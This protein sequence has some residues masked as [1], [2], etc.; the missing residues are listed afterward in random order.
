MSQVLGSLAFPLAR[1]QAGKTDV[2]LFR[3]Q[4]M[5][6]LL[7]VKKEMPKCWDTQCHLISLELESLKSTLYHLKW[8]E[9][10]LPFSSLLCC[11]PPHAQCIFNFSLVYLEATESCAITQGDRRRTAKQNGCNA[12][13][14]CSTGSLFQQWNWLLIESTP[15]C[16]PA[17]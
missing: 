15:F 2:L 14:L 11:S 16:C 13:K 3:G 17:P 5:C 7:W 8:V 6:N 4:I 1:P 9:I 12:E 10:F